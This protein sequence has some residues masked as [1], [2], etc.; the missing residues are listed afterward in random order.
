MKWRRNGRI[1]VEVEV[2]ME[3]G[4]ICVSKGK[5]GKARYGGR[6]SRLGSNVR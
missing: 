3:G 5:K 4:K 1:E 2:E 6:W